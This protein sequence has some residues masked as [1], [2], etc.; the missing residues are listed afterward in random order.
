MLNEKAF[1]EAYK[2][3][4]IMSEKLA[5]KLVQHG[6]SDDEMTILKQGVYRKF[7]ETYLAYNYSGLD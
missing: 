3:A 2:V 5:S 7:L 1:Q 6:I 4:K